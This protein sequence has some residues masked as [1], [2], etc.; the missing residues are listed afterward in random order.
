MTFDSPQGIFLF[1]QLPALLNPFRL[2]RSR[3]KTSWSRPIRSLRPQ[4]A[5]PNQLRDDLSSATFDLHPGLGSPTDD[6]E[7]VITTCSPD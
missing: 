3:R 2:F 7:A 4:A 5:S 1:R 6:E